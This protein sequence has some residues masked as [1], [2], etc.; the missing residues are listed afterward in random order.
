MPGSTARHGFDE[1]VVRFMHDGPGMSAEEN[2]TKN[3]IALRFDSS[4]PDLIC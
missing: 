2:V 4:S 1:R 3:L